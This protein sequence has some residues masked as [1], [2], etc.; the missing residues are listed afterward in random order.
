MRL[1]LVCT[2]ILFIGCKG[3]KEAM[4]KQEDIVNQ[5]GIELLIQDEYSAFEEQETMVIKSAKSLNA[6]FSKINMTRKPGIPVPVIDFKTE[7]VVI[8]CSGKRDDAAKSEIRKM[9]ENDNEMVFSAEHKIPEDKKSY[10][11]TPFSLYKMP[12]TDKKIV[13]DQNI[14]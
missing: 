13:I 2:M 11:T 3:Q 6:F 1:L 14:K 5:E 7:M 4:E 9:S 10:K 12:L 8:Y